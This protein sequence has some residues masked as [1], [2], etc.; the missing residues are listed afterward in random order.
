MQDIKRL[1]SSSSL[2]AIRVVSSA[3]L[4]LLIFLLAFSLLPLDKYWMCCFF[5]YIS[6]TCLHTSDFSLA[7]FKYLHSTHTQTTEVRD[8]Y[9]FQS[10]HHLLLALFI[11]SFSFY[12]NNLLYKSR[13]MS[14]AHQYTVSPPH[15]N[16][17]RSES[18]FPS[19][20]CS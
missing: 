17:F 14:L 9:I 20:I 13:P 12:W 10:L 16:K 4:R 5:T 19:P 3:Y 1:S 7:F 2:S 8:K 15:M 18:T 11:I 6:L